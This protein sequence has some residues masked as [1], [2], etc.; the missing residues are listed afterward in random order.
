VLRLDRAEL[1]GQGSA[2]IELKQEKETQ[3]CFHQ[4]SSDI[5]EIPPSWRIQSLPAFACRVYPRASPQLLLPPPHFSPEKIAADKFRLTAL[6]Y[7][8][9]FCCVGKKKGSFSISYC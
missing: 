7:L 5:E 1:A 3:V 9:S 6:D 4:K 8:H 2:I